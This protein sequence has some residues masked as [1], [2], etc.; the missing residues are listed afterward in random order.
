M[1]PIPFSSIS[2]EEKEAFMNTC[3]ENQFKVT[4][5]DQSK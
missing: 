1:L 3:C 2:I 5:R 4:E